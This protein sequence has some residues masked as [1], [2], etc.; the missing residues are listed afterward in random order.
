[1]VVHS[2]GKVKEHLRVR[3]SGGRSITSLHCAPFTARHGESEVLEV[4][5]QSPVGPISEHML[6]DARVVILRKLMRNLHIARYREVRQ[7]D[8]EKR[9]QSFR[10]DGGSRLGH[11]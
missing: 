5:G 4:P 1:M 9:K 2:Y 10:S 6:H 11:D 7:M 3:S 8:A